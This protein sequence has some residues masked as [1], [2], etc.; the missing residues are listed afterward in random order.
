MATSRREPHWTCGPRPDS[1]GVQ[2]TGEAVLATPKPL[3]IDQLWHSPRASPLRDNSSHNHI[4][5]MRQRHHQVHPLQPAS[6]S[7]PTSRLGSLGEI[8]GAMPRHDVLPRLDF[9]QSPLHLFARRAPPDRLSL[10]AFGGEEGEQGFAAGGV[11]EVEILPAPA[12][13]PGGEGLV[14]CFLCGPSGVR[15]SP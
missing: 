3:T 4:P 9:A 11:G 1:P 2:S 5:I 12:A 13:R 10:L 6:S 15:L 14:S 7:L 8:C